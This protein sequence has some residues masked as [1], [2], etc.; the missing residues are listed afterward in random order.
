MRQSSLAEVSGELNVTIA[1]S[2]F[3]SFASIPPPSCSTGLPS[4][5]D[6]IDAHD[7]TIDAQSPMTAFGIKRRSRSE[8]PDCWRCRQWDPASTRPDSARFVRTWRQSRRGALGGSKAFERNLLRWHAG[9]V[10]HRINL[11]FDGI[12]RR[13]SIL[14]WSGQRAVIWYGVLVKP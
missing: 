7:C 2:R 5:P 4:T 1:H 10:G 8:Q 3:G 13:S 9:V 11:L 6:I 14:E 12:R